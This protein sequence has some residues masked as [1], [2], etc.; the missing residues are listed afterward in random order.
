MGSCHS[1]HTFSDLHVELHTSKAGACPI[2]RL[3]DGILYMILIDVA[4]AEPIFDIHGLASSHME[5]PSYYDCLGWTRLSAVC[6][7]WRAAVLNAASLWAE[8]AFGFPLDMAVLALIRSGTA[9]LEIIIPAHDEKG[10]ELL[11]EV[12]GRKKWGPPHTH[13]DR[14]LDIAAIHSHRMGVFAA[15][16]LSSLEYH[17]IFKGGIF[18]HLTIL[19][20]EYGYNK[21]G[22]VAPS[23]EDLDDLH[24]I[25]PL[26]READL[27]STLPIAYDNRPGLHLELPSLRM[28][29]LTACNKQTARPT[30]VDQLR[31]ILP[32][33]R[34]LPSLECLHMDLW[35]R[36]EI[37][38]T[39]IFGK[40]PIH[41][42]ALREVEFTGSLDA[43]L[44]Q[45]F[46]LVSPVIL[47]RISFALCATGNIQESSESLRQVGSILGCLLRSFDLDSIY[48]SGKPFE[49]STQSLALPGIQMAACSSADTL[50]MGHK[51]EELAILLPGQHA[52][53]TALSLAFPSFPPES[54]EDYPGDA[55]ELL[56]PLLLT[57]NSMKT[58]ILD[59]MTTIRWE[60]AMRGVMQSYLG[61]VTTLYCISPF[62]YSGEES[63]S[64][65]CTAAL[66]LLYSAEKHDAQTQLP[67]APLPNPGLLQASPNSPLSKDILPRLETIVV[68]LDT[69]RF[70]MKELNTVWISGDI[71]AWWNEIIQALVCR[72]DAGLRVRKL[73]IIGG[74]SSEK[75]RRRT[76]RKDAK[77]LARAA[78][79]VD[80][81]VDERTVLDGPK[82]GQRSLI[83]R[84]MH[85]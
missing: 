8:Y 24:I 19:S 38:W 44:D 85:S 40:G 22:L 26:V 49:Q 31:W 45:F 1:L 33:V 4:D 20:L 46:G 77:M 78:E 63:D 56:S 42:G 57:D 67:R 13:R 84:L 65:P 51:M 36:F 80:E 70:D 35:T 9:P 52:P 83:S 58:L 21:S 10:S 59:G 73:Q 74:W 17:L 27:S 34:T 61:G 54:R 71:R 18:N 68:S 75:L 69:R 48:L 7:R 23:G 81:V 60:T 79:L 53:G 72:C 28:L 15:K 76:A 3:P 55:L 16:D 50:A 11:C 64:L 25:A 66:R 5:N 2:S 41:L 47:P 37:D 30:S 32:F 62:S 43:H 6:R 39:Q 29:H 12:A 82:L 14:L